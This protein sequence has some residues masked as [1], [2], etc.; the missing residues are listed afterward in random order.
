M[1]CHVDTTYYDSLAREAQKEKLD[2]FTRAF[3]ETTAFLKE[4]HPIVF[5][6]LM[7]HSSFVNKSYNEHKKDDLNRI[8]KEHGSKLNGFSDEDILKMHDAGLI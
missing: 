5:S 2:N 3:C 1:P 6:E 8:K 4:R 7:N